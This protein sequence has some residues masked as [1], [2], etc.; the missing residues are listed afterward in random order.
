MSP[1]VG[2]DTQLQ[3]ES[4]GFMSHLALLVG[5]NLVTWLLG[6]VAARDP[7]KCSPQLDDC[8]L[9]KVVEEEDKSLLWTGSHLALQVLALDARGL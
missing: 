6:N 5:Q 4:G 8:F 2:S 3:R 7:G 9:K 1:Q